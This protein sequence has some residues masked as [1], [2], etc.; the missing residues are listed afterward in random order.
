M[1]RRRRRGRR[2][3]RSTRGNRKREDEEE[4]KRKEEEEEEKRKEAEE[5]E[6]K[7]K[8]AEKKRKEAEENKRKEVEK[9]H[10]RKREEEEEEKRKEE[11]EEKKRKRHHISPSSF[12]LEGY[13]NF[14]SFKDIRDL[15][16]T[17]Q[18]ESVIIDCYVNTCLFLPR[19]ENLNIFKTFGYLGATLKGY[20]QSCEDDKSK[21]QHFDYSFKRLDRAPTELDL[22]FFPKHVEELR[23][24]MKGKHIDSENWSLRYPDPCPQQ[25][26]GD[27]C[28]IFT[29][30]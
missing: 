6:K 17:G 24:Y 25:R 16:F 12:T 27:D 4:E 2:R 22:L 30:K 11:E 10:K 8:E 14:L 23:I 18:S 5:A 13:D 3:R 9:E 7:R 19:Q 26:S 20:V 21:Q 1:R 15:L 28:A 29:C